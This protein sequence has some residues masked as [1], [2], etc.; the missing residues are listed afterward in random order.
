MLKIGV[1]TFHRSINYGCY[2]QARCLVDGLRA[3]GYH[4]VLLDHV[5]RRVEIAEWKCAYRPVL[6][7]PVPK[8][9]YPLYREKTQRFFRAIAALPLS[10]GFQLDNPEHMEHYDLVVVGSD[11]VW[12]LFH[13]WYGKTPLFYGE[14]LRADRVISYA[15]SFGNYPAAYGLRSEWADRLRNFD[16]ISVRDENSRVL[17]WNATGICPAVVLDPCLQFQLTVAQHD[18]DDRDAPYVAVYGHNFSDLYIH[19]IQ[20]WARRRALPLISIGYRNDWA[21]VQWLTAGPH[22]FARFMARAEAVATNFFHGCVFALRSAK[23]FACETSP[24]RNQ[25]IWNLLA[26]VG[27]ERH[28]ITENTPGAELNA[29]LCAPVQPCIMAKIAQLRELSSAYLNQALLPP[30]AQCA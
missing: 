26:A 11:E 8:S 24:Y 7:S 3:L 4:A 16:N 2:W 5:S 22:D 23:P 6:P 12:N 10:P 17:V 19:K 28:L 18:G 30:Q 27:G 15:A 14:G 21:D 25:K 9:D 1:L 29:H 13:P 20:R